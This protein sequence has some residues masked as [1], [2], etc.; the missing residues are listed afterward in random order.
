MQGREGGSFAV[1]E[2]YR[3]AAF[4]YHNK[5]LSS[6]RQALSHV[7][8][9]N[10]HYFFICGGFLV[11]TSAASRRTRSLSSHEKSA[12]PSPLSP[13]LECIELMRGSHLVQQTADTYEWIKSG[14]MS[15]M[16]LSVVEGYESSM[17]EI[18]SV[19][20]ASLISM[21]QQKSFGEKRKVC[22]TAAEELRQTFRV[23]AGEKE[24][25]IVFSW[26]S[27]CSSEYLAL[28]KADEP[29]ALLV[30]AYWCVL[31]N[32]INWCWIVEGWAQDILK[33]II[34]SI[35]DET[36]KPWLRWP[37]D[38]VIRPDAG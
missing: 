11:L 36:W 21:L 28:L 27:T 5:A 34:T 18:A 32:K 10:C 12:A 38:Q 29:E 22:Q 31:L 37:I 1:T 2:K 20:I 13:I 24:I 16:V 14:P 9:E 26:P 33:T 8:Q 3:I 7:T 19:E 17:D 6:F 30:M 35:L 25:G 23:D 15:A 4:L